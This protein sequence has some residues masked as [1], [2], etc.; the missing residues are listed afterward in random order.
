MADKKYLVGIFNDED[1]VMDAVQKIRSKG[2][3]IH[4]VFCPYPVHGLDHVLGYERPRMGVPAFLFGIT[5]SFIGPSLLALPPKS[6]TR[7]F[8]FGLLCNANFLPSKVDRS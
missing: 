2:I 7:Q 8:F 6:N 3:K 1:V 5:G 4:E